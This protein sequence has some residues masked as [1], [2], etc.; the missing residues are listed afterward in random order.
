M[1]LLKTIDLKGFGKKFQGKVRDYYKLNGKR[2]LITTDRISAFDKVLGFIPYK[3]QV[4][5]QLSSFWFKNTEDIVP[6]HLISVPD[7]NATIVK[8]C[9]SYPV[10]I[11][12]RGYISGVT[13]TSLWHNYNMGKRKVYGLKFPDGLKKNQK[14]EKPVITPTTR[15]TGPGGHDEKI[16]KSEI[17]KRKIISKK[18]YEEMEKAALAL[19]KKGT[20]ICEKAGLILV[21]TKYEFGDYHSQLT[22][23][24]E[25]HTPDSSRFWIKKT[26]QE[27]LKKGLEPENFDKEFFRLWYA[28]RNYRGDGSPPKMPAYYQKKV[29]QRYIQVYEKI[30]GEKFKIEKEN[31]QKR[32][33]KNLSCLFDQVVIIAGSQKD[34]EFVRRIEKSLSKN[35]ICFKTFYASA[36]KQPKDVLDI[37]DHYKKNSKKVVFITVAGRSNALSGFVAGNSPYPV[38]ACP[39]FKDKVDY[40]VNIHSSLQMPSNVPVMTVIDPEN[41]SL[42]TYRIL[43]FSK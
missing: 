43:N 11:V 8:N 26:Y 10:E 20:E 28:K 40:L 14:L 17:L 22:L 7:P 30:T 2:V 24:D 15:G 39:P 1:S 3:G 13:I 42:A 4:L 31:I 41:A 29:S 16:S 37:I 6:N 5:N 32:I 9:Q 12:V 33:K 27:R 38:I 36:H 21:D 19:F 25:V 34:K 23:I 35:Q 18:T